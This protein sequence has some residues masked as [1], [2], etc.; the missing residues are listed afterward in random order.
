MNI[1]SNIFENK[2]INKL[3]KPAYPFKKCSKELET[4]FFP[5]VGSSNPLSKWAFGLA[6]PISAKN[7]QPCNMF[8][9]TGT[10]K[11]WQT[12]LYNDWEVKN[13][14]EYLLFLEELLMNSCSIDDN[15]IIPI[16]NE[17]NYDIIYN[18]LLDCGYEPDYAHNYASAIPIITKM[19]KDSKWFVVPDK[20][21]KAWDFVRIAFYILSGNSA[22]YISR[23]KAFD[24]LIEVGKKANYYYDDWFSYTSAYLYGRKLWVASGGGYDNETFTETNTDFKRIMAF[25]CSPLSIC[26]T[27]PFGYEDAKA[28]DDEYTCHNE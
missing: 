5:I 7:Y 15:I 11:A 26:R 21:L 16:L 19:F 12:A 9:P 13:K 14:E 17:T 18:Y 22:D 10:P 3:S 1:F 6:G 8:F 28:L 25:N 23:Q 24:S 27:V 20:S 4:N 2:K